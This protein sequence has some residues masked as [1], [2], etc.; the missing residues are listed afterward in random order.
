VIGHPGDARLCSQFRTVAT[1]PAR[2]LPILDTS[3]ASLSDYSSGGY[4]A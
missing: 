1:M 4:K 2:E 3:V